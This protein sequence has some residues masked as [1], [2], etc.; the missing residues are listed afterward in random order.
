MVLFSLIVMD[1]PAN[2][3]WKDQLMKCKQVDK[4]CIVECVYSDEVSD[5]LQMALNKLQKEL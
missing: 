3:Q 2:Q 4:P 1:G 5:P